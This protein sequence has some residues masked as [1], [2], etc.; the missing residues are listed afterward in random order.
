[1]SIEFLTPKTVC[2]RTTLSRPTI[3]RLVADGLFPAPI[4]L[5]KC[6]LAFLADQ[7]EKWMAERAGGSAQ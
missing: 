4:R 6:R 2:Q 1:M 5:T 3:D 7:I